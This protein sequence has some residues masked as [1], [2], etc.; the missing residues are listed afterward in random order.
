M[1]NPNV[2]E[3]NPHSYIRW[4]EISKGFKFNVE[5]PRTVKGYRN[6]LCGPWKL[7]TPGPKH[8]EGKAAG[9]AV[10]PDMRVKGVRLLSLHTPFP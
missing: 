9:K 8:T 7:G 3:A 6:V 5:M 2:K 10:C 4:W 1:R